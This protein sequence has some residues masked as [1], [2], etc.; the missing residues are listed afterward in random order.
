[1]SQVDTIL[2]KSTGS[3]NLIKI[4]TG[5]IYYVIDTSGK[6]KTKHFNNY[7]DANEVFLL[8]VMEEQFG[9]NDNTYKDYFCPT[10]N[11]EWRVEGNGGLVSGCWPNC[12]NC[13]TMAEEKEIESVR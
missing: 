8:C 9:D 7:D 2:L 10:C 5:E 12:P 3:Y 13:G 6:K 11:H 1:M 4:S